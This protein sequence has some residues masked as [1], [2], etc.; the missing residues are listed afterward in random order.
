MRVDETSR[1]LRL[2]DGK[3]VPVEEG[4]VFKDVVDHGYREKTCWYPVEGQ[5]VLEGQSW[6]YIIEHIMSTRSKYS[7]YKN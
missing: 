7:L 5:P 6:N 3:E 1:K 4:V 2:K